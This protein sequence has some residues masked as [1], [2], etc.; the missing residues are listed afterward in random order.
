MFLRQL[1][2]ENYTLRLQKIEI[3]SKYTST[4]NYAKEGICWLI[5]QLL[6]QNEDI[7]SQEEQLNLLLLAFSESLQSHL[8]LKEDFL[9]E[10]KNKFNRKVS[11][12]DFEHS[13]PL[14]ILLFNVYLYKRE[15]LDYFTEQLGLN[16]DYA[17]DLRR[18][19]KFL[20]TNFDKLNI[21]RVALVVSQ[22]TP[23]HI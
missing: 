1:R 18:W 2:D 8:P 5:Q 23:K 7:Y 21:D 17:T 3:P 15:E 9:T 14:S 6:R 10:I 13:Y 11:I 22:V 20:S 19:K 4:F 12:V 16:K